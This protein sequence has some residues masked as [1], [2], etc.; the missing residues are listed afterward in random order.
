NIILAASV[1]SVLVTVL[2]LFFINRDVFGREQAEMQL[3]V[4][5]ANLDTRV[6]ERTADL[7]RAR[8]DLEARVR[9]R[10]IDL[11]RA[12]EELQRA[13]A[14]A[15]A[16]NR[17]KSEFLA[18][19]SH[20]LRTPLNSVIGFTNILLKNKAG[21]LREQDLTYLQRVHDNGRHLL[22]LINEVLDLAKVEAGR[23]ELEL[24]TVALGDLVSSTLAALEGQLKGKD[25]RLIAELPPRLTPIQADAGKLKQVLINLVGNAIK[26][27]DRGGVTVRVEADPADGRPLALDVIDTGVGIPQDKL[28]VI[29]EAFQQ[30]DA[31]TT[32]QYGGTGLGLTIA[33]SL[34]GLMGYEIKVHSSVGHGS[35]F[36]VLIGEKKSSGEPRKPA[37]AR[38]PTQEIRLRA[39]LATGLS[40][41][42]GKQ[43][44]VIDDDSDSRILLTRYLED[45]GCRVI[46]ADSGEQGLRVGEQLRPDLI[47]LDLMMPGMNGWD[48]L[49][50]L[51]AHPALSRVPVV[52]V[53]IVAREN[54]GTILGA[55]DLLDKPVSRE[56]LHALLLRNLRSRKGRALVV[57]DNDD[58]RRLLSAYLA[59]EGLET[60]EAVNGADAL[61]RL[62]RFDADL[63]ILDVMMPVMDGL[64][65]LDALR[66]D[67]RYLH[68]PVVVVTAKELTPQESERLRA[69]ASVVLRKGDDLALG[70]KR[71]VGKVLGHRGDGAGAER[72]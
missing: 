65:F 10:T 53:S 13:T 49:K 58:A 3:A 7:E 5:N 35:M 33:R 59:E 8:T 36:R 31:S 15:E 50:A 37:A 44:L 64:T 22:T 60:C 30:A 66:R 27:T 11:A 54:R 1:L 43:V 23:M 16:A 51:K 47:V 56:A 29:F 61:G 52:V 46:A 14:K 62:E 42:T 70:L 6:K 17:T 57:D 9:E 48:V 45:C 32:R 26:F 2:S 72:G 69:D 63:V 24:G 67:A 39:E 21:N 68:L 25:V 12:N 71:V 40:D 41:L 38:S 19:M 28:D 20:E 55:V 34:C 4:A 18:N